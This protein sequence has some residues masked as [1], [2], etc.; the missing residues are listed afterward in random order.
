[1]VLYK[2]NIAPKTNVTRIG[3]FHPVESKC[4]S[5]CGSG[6]AIHHTITVEIR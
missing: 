3:S 6:G 1:M 2:N 5:V 4:T